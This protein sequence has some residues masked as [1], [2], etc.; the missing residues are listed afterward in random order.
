[1]PACKATHIKEYKYQRVAKICQ[2][3][4]ESLPVNCYKTFYLLKLFTHS[5]THS[6]FHCFIS[7]GTFCHATAIHTIDAHPSLT[8]IC[9]PL[10]PTSFCSQS[11]V[12]MM[13]SPP[14]LSSKLS[15]FVLAIVCRADYSSWPL[16]IH[17]K[18]VL[19][20]N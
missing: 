6:F 5:L 7:T 16:E 17:T 11:K 10:S 1:M 2:F 13:Y 3:R 15:V 12:L 8:H 18:K 4:S 20:I 9:R 19:W 14:W